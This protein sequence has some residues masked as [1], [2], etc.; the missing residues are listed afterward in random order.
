MV[1]Q[2]RQP[3]REALGPLQASL[4]SLQQAALDQGQEPL[5]RIA[6]RLRYV[7]MGEPLEDLDDEE[8]RGY[9]EASEE[10]KHDVFEAVHSQ[11]CSQKLSRAGL[12]W[13][14]GSDHGS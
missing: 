2:A 10:L 3:I 12:N 1:V 11:A 5:A 6:L 8:W 14:G 9:F 7:L 4:K 13:V